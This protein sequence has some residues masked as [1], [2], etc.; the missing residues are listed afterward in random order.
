MNRYE[1]TINVA[2]DGQIYAFVMYRGVFAAA[3]TFQPTE[4]MSAIV[5]W[6]NDSK[7]WTRDLAMAERL[8]DT[9]SYDHNDGKLHLITGWSQVHSTFDPNS[10]ESLAKLVRTLKRKAPVPLSTANAQPPLEGLPIPTAEQ[11]ANAQRFNQIGIPEGVTA[12]GI[13][14]PKQRYQQPAVSQARTKEIVESIFA[15]M[16]GD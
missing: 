11:L 1:F 3:R 9:I 4:P 5:E 12:A 2:P 7:L 6:C 13:R 10:D 15:D 16:F 8:N 14:K